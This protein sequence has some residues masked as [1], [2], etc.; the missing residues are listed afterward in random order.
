MHLS[1]P[2]ILPYIKKLSSLIL[3]CLLFKWI[4]FS[5]YFKYFIIL[6]FHTVI[7]TFIPLPQLLPGASPTL[8]LPNFLVSLFENCCGMIRYPL[9]P[10]LHCPGCSSAYISRV[11]LASGTS[12][13]ACISWVLPAPRTRRKM[14]ATMQEEL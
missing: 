2:F 11:M 3:A 8:Y 4:V 10:E 1:F 9:F 5:F 12:S 6:K 7:F 13:S 14:A